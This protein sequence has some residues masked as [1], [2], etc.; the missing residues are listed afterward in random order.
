MM[1]LEVAG[2]R[3][4]Y[5]VLDTGSFRSSISAF[6]RDELEGAGLLRDEA[7]SHRD[8]PFYTLQGLSVEGQPIPDVRVLVS[9]TVSRHGI[10]GI[11]ALPSFSSSARF[12]SR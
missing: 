5:M 4:V 8:S 12:A 9:P 1:R 6:L 7:R 10:D 2:F 11:S 3:N